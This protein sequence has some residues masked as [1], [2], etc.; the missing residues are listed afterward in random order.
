MNFKSL[1]LAIV[2]LAAVSCA[3]S[4]VDPAVKKGNRIAFGEIRGATLPEGTKI[5]F[6]VG[7]PVNYSNE[8]L[9]VDASGNVTSVNDL[10]WQPAQ[11]QRS[12]V[13]A[14]APYQEGLSSGNALTFSVKTDQS[15]EADFKASD[16]I[17]CHKAAVDP[18]ADR[19]S[20]VFSHR[21]SQVE[22]YFD[23]RSGKNIR[24]VE[25]GEVATS[26]SIDLASGAWTTGSEKA[27]VAAFK[28]EKSYFAI[29]P[30]QTAGLKIKVTLEDETSF[31]YELDEADF[32]AGKN[33][34]NSE[35]PLKVGADAPKQ[36]SFS[37]SVS[38][39]V[40]GGQLHLKGEEPDDYDTIASLV[41]TATST[42]TSFEVVLKNAVV[43]YKFQNY[44][45]LEDASGAILIYCTNDLNAGD[46]V[47]GKVSGKTKVYNGVPE[48]T[49][50]NLSAAN[51]TT[52]TDI[53]LTTIT[54]SELLSDYD[55]YLSCRILLKGVV[56][57]KGT[58]AGSTQT[59]TGSISQ[60][61]S[62]IDI[63]A[64]YT[65]SPA[66][67]E[68]G[69]EGDL[70]AF[71]TYYKTS[72]QLSIYESSQLQTAPEPS[73]EETAFARNTTAFGVYASTDTD[74]PVP[75]MTYVELKDQIA[76]GATPTG[77]NFSLAS[78]DDNRW[79]SLSLNISN[80]RIGAAGTAD[81]SSSDG[82]AATYDVKVVNRSSSQLWL[83]DKT[84]HVGFIIAY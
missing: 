76:C 50:L 21:F 19:I 58:T 4:D 63:Y 38:D 2:A 11:T 28:A 47:S 62:S 52:T 45:H 61:G 3:K 55:R 77:R 37:F 20:I 74:S 48:I 41:A 72:Q 73:A 29:I 46:V 32:A 71:P 56:V 12:M 36:I 42:E 80:P 66:E 14:Y 69:L 13:F 16:L 30:P 49:S 64:T 79:C 8:I 5:G 17:A 70:I 10:F 34:S 6:F 78:L 25:I 15:A 54:L 23:N 53:P 82:T 39:W 35:S 1:F 83:E 65:Q 43:T 60:G 31:E 57:T 68:S 22:L 24:K 59:R 18:S 67:L 84:S 27:V 40:D 33:Y 81:Y 7:S 44:T 75:T 51:L 9:T 26:A